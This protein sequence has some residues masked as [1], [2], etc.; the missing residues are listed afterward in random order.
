M[1]TNYELFLEIFQNTDIKCSELDF[2]NLLLI[3]ENELI[4]NR[5]GDQVNLKLE[6]CV[7]AFNLQNEFKYKSFKCIGFRY[8]AGSNAFYAVYTRDEIVIFGFYMKLTH[9]RKFLNKLGW[10]WKSNFFKTFYLVQKNLN[11]I[12]Y[13]TIDL[14]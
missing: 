10:N 6:E 4:Y 5:D 1:K 7:N 2:S 13:T 8:F 14:T 11:N 9:F 3:T 12:S